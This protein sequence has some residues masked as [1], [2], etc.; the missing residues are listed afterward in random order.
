MARLENNA[1]HGLKAHSKRIAVCIARHTA[2]ALLC[3]FTVL[4]CVPTDLALMSPSMVSNSLLLTRTSQSCHTPS[5]MLIH[6]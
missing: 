5:F 2:N 3:V 6:L 1:Y 4:Q